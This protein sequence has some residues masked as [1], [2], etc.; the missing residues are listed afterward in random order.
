M[1]RTE[2]AWGGGNFDVFLDLGSRSLVPYFSAEAAE[3]IHEAYGGLNYY[4]SR[5]G[6]SGAGWIPGNIALRMVS[7]YR[8][9]THYVEAP[10]LDNP[11]DTLPGIGFVI[12]PIAYRGTAPIPADWP[13]VIVQGAQ[14]PYEGEA[15]GYDRLYLLDAE[16]L[17][18]FLLGNEEKFEDREVL[19]RY[20]PAVGADPTERTFPV[21][22]R[23]DAYMDY[24]RA[25]VGLFQRDL[26]FNS[27][28][29]VH[30]EPNRFWSRL[31]IQYVSGRFYKIAQGVCRA[32]YARE[33]LSTVEMLQVAAPANV[34][35]LSPTLYLQ[36]S[37]I[38]SFEAVGLVEIDGEEVAAETTLEATEAIKAMGGDFAQVEAKL[39]AVAREWLAQERERHEWEAQGP[40]EESSGIFE[41]PE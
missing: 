30:G 24:R 18:Q 31:G 34:Q 36:E 7:T 4:R 28:A 5:S 14:R 27:E 39:E 29:G 37:A 9:D 3:K 11:A 1:A 25:V 16:G 10:S 2:L 23:K 22:V 41:P 6:L 19:V 26:A 38:G 15:V 20:I 32:H 21:R 13:V 17:Q 33:E 40:P 12:A 8:V 35:V